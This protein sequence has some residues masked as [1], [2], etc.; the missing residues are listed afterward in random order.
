[1]SDIKL[2]MYAVRSGDGKYLCKGNG[3]VDGLERARLYVK[4]GPARALVT[5]LATKF[6][7]SVFPELVEL[8]VT[9]VVVLDEKERLVKAQ[10]RKA[11]REARWAAREAEWARKQA[12]R[13]LE[14]AK[15]EVAR[16]FAKLKG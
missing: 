1:M 10:L 16:V 5:L 3:W 11:V 6:P 2:R 13:K 15:A 4:P 7:N 8:H 12:L 14:D 9:D